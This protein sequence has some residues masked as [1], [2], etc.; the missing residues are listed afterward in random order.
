M[1]NNC[2]ICKEQYYSISKATDVCE[3]HEDWF[4]TECQVCGRMCFSDAVGICIK[5]SKRAVRIE[6]RAFGEDD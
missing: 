5:D 4:I 1:N 3:R 2:P 6:D